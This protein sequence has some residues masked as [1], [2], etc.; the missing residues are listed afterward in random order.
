MVADLKT[1]TE[2]DY[3]TVAEAASML[4]VGESAILRW[5]EI[6]MLPS[7]CVAD[8]PVA[9][10]RDDLRKFLGPVRSTSTSMSGEVMTADHPVFRPL[11]PEEREHGLAWIEE[12]ERR[13]KELMKRLGIERFEPESWV[14]LDEARAERDK[15]LNDLP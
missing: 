2:T 11:T 13:G 15:R 6:G 10:A 8:R 1:D 14:L 9:V 4:G 7:H 3:L 12:T 5:I